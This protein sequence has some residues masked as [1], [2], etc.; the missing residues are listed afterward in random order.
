MALAVSPKTWASAKDWEGVKHVLE[1]LYIDEN[2]SLR[3]V[4]NEMEIQFGFRAT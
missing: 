2:K 1:R 4:K 3:Q